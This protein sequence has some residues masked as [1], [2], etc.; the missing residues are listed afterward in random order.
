MPVKCVMPVRTVMFARVVTPVLHVKPAIQDVLGV[1]AVKAAMLVN[2]R[3]LWIT[4]KIASDVRSVTPP[5]E[6]PNQ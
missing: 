1:I 2:R 6:V 4:A 3:K 5:K